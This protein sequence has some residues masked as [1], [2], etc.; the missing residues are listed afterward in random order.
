V[1]ILYDHPLSGNCHK[2]RLFLSMVN[3][4]YQSIYVDVLSRI[5]RSAAYL[6]INPLGQVPV[7]SD[8]GVVVRDGQ[9]ILVYLATRYAPEW[10]AQTPLGWARIMEW[11]AIAANEI[12][13]R[14][15]LARV[16][17]LVPGHVEG[18]EIQRVREKSLELLGLVDRHLQ[19]REWLAADRPTIADLACFPYVGLA[20]EG[21]LP[22]DDY[23]NIIKWIDRIAALP[24]Y[25]PMPGLPGSASL[26]E[27]GEEQQIQRW[28]ESY[29]S[30]SS[31]GR[32]A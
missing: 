7:L 15:Q 29:V 32:F 13:A 26:G 19:A 30:R 3:L 12:G 1:I 9:A 16:H 14:L 25:V 6:S 22:L 20:R 23:T 18:I 24:G 10:A 28:I 11:L 27:A 17:H 4:P 5:N 31:W 21:R 2:V 8:G